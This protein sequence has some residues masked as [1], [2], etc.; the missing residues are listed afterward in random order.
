MTKSEHSTHVGFSFDDVVQKERKA[1]NERRSEMSQ[2][3]SDGNDLV[4][5][6]LSGGGIRSAMFN[7]GLLQS[8]HKSH[9]MDHVDY[10]ASVSGGGY[11]AGYYASLGN[12]PDGLDK[13][14]S[15]TRRKRRDRRNGNKETSEHANSSA[16]DHPLDFADGQQ[17]RGSQS[18]EPS[19]GLHA[20][21]GRFLMEGQYLNRPLAFFPIYIMQTAFM[22]LMYLG[23]LIFTGSIVALFFR[24]FDYPKVRTH[25]ELIA[26]GTDLAAALIGIFVIMATYCLGT[27]F[28]WIGYRFVGQT[29]QFPHSRFLAVVIGASLLGVMVMLGNGD[30]NISSV[31][32]GLLPSSLTWQTNVQLPLTA[33]VFLAFLPLIKFRSLLQSERENASLFERFALK[34][35]L[36]LTIGGGTLA[37]IGFLSRENISGYANRRE[38]TLVVDD[39]ID[40]RAF[41]TYLASDKFIAVKNKTKPLN[42]LRKAIKTNEE[43]RQ[44]LFPA[45]YKWDGPFRGFPA[46]LLP[47]SFD[48]CQRVFQVSAVKLGYG[49]TYDAHQYIETWG[50]E[51]EARRELVNAF[52]ETYFLSDHPYTPRSVPDDPLTQGLLAHLQSK[53]TSTTKD[54]KASEESVVKY[55]GLVEPKPIETATFL[56][57]FRRSCRVGPGKFPRNV[58]D[59][60]Q[61]SP[62]ETNKFRRLLLELSEPQLFKR[63]AMV[64][65]PVVLAAD[66]ACRQWWCLWSLVAFLV[67]SLVL[68][69]NQQSPLRN[70]YQQTLVRTFLQRDHSRVDAYLSDIKPHVYGNPYPLFLGALRLIEPTAAEQDLHRSNPGKIDDSVGSEWYSFLMSPLFCGWMPVGPK[71]SPADRLHRQNGET[72]KTYCE[73]K[74]YLG[75]EFKF[76]D[77]VAISGAALT[78]YMASNAALVALMHAFNLRLEQWLPN[79]AKPS[80]ANKKKFVFWTLVREW[81]RAKLSHQASQNWDWGIV[82]DGGFREFLGVEELLARR[83]RVIIASDAGCNNGLYEFGVLA[84]LVRKARLDHQ[85][86]FLDLDHELPLDASRLRHQVDAAKNVAQHFIVGRIRYPEMETV[87]FCTPTG[88]I[89][90]RVQNKTGLFVYLQMTLTG[91]EDIDLQQFRKTNPTFPDE[92]IANQF[93]TKD[94]VES[95]RQLGEHIGRLISQEFSRI[96][97]REPLPEQGH[98]DERSSSCETTDWDSARRQQR[99]IELERVFRVAYQHECKLETAIS[100]RDAQAEWYGDYESHGIGSNSTPFSPAML[101]LSLNKYEQSQVYR[102]RIRHFVF[103]VLDCDFEATDWGKGSP[104]QLK[105]TPRWYDLPAILVE[106]NRRYSGFRSE[107]PKRYFQIGSRERTVQQLRGLLELVVKKSGTVE[108]PD[109]S[110]DRF[111]SGLYSF[112]GSVQRATFREHGVETVTDFLACFVKW[113]SCSAEVKSDSQRGQVSEVSD[114]K[115]S[116]RVPK[117]PD[118]IDTKSSNRLLRLIMVLSEPWKI[119]RDLKKGPPITTNSFVRSILLWK[120]DEVNVPTSDSEFGLHS[121]TDVPFTAESAERVFTMLKHAD[122]GVRHVACTYLCEYGVDAAQELK[123]RT[124]DE[125]TRALAQEQQTSVRI[126]LCK[127]LSWVGEDNEV[128]TQCLH[129]RVGDESEAPAVRTVCELL[130]K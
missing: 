37:T 56:Q 117:Y 47:V 109:Q 89:K 45:E 75:G 122:A 19:T 121:L 64:S 21:D 29:I 77:A 28:V 30:F 93:Y 20:T 12:Q 72:L 112:I 66:Q 34:L 39:I 18:D 80:D 91:D 92:P 54:E 23:V 110:A 44:R 86:E 69:F 16:M 35:I 113:L 51:R 84:D 15:H 17:H 120:P 5:L 90:T 1:I 76:S 3:E 96:A 107:A 123:S 78:P 62:L 67:I 83:C 55:L 98:P 48:W 24:A 103:S 97:S 57:L 130:V 87:T 116:V 119:A 99:I 118:F 126:E 22:L 11:I 6:S 52:N 111:E 124:I 10:M 82:A 127:A 100:V 106:C 14:R 73:T 114:G 108:S 60:R 61:L 65:T 33:G 63:R 129:D 95:L 85:I 26:S 81:F 13:D 88:E 9:V 105:W 115:A 59:A 125:L 31:S 36:M 27:V 58:F 7:L 8:L 32:T 68:D 94:Q 102:H 74:K 128:V 70:F 104:Q 79:P 25:L 49:K 50:V 71:G 4:G 2:P 53:I 101:E 43:L 42:D 46:D 41:A 38:P 40:D